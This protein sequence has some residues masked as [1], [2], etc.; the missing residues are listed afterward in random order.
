MT[1]S[2]TQ[3]VRSGPM[4]GERRFDVLAVGGVD[5]DIVMRVDRLPGHGEKVLGT[6]VGNLPGGTVANF[7]CAASRLGLRAASL[8]TVGPDDAGKLIIEDF[9]HFGV[10]TDFVLVRPEV[11]THFTVILIEP[12]GERSIIVVPRFT[13]AYDDAFLERAIPQSRA[14]YTMPNRAD[15]FRQMGRMARAHGV[16]VMIDVEATIGADRET[17]EEML[18]WVNIASFNE[19]GLE[20]IGG[21]EA[22]I[23]GARQLLAF[24][25]HTVVVTLGKRGSLAVTADEAVEMPGRDVAV[26]DTTGA[27][28]TFN[29]AFLT[30]TLRGLPLA[31]R[32]AFANAAAALAVTGLGPRG[33]LPTSAEVESFL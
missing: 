14:L 32:L 25:P 26:V 23:E 4:A 3:P 2:S 24:G 8:A 16:Q 15:L 1:E 11:E 31:G 18:Q 20:A 6:F 13:E 21:E 7:A 17:L 5:V 12:S 30:A 22:T 28:D 10:A 27:G 9:E 19:A 29:A 33:R